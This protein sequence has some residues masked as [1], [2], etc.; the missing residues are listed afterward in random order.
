MKILVW[1]A[2]NNGHVYRK[3]LEEKTDYEFLGYIDNNSRGDT[4]F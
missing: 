1:G 4:S 2:G 3:Y